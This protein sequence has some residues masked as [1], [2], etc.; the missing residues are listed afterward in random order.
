MPA[1]WSPCVPANDLFDTFPNSY[2]SLGYAT[3][4]RIEL[5]QVPSMVALRHIRFDDLGALT[6]AIDAIVSEREW[7]G[8]RVDAVDGVVFEPSESYL[9]LARWSDEWTERGVHGAA[10]EWVT[11]PVRRSTTGRSSSGRPTR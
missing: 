3:R 10:P 11:T 4:I 9:T 8:T 1:R 6:K 7:D 5:E 2:G